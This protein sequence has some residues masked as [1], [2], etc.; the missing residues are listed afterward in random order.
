MPTA[1]DC[2]PAFLRNTDL[3]LSRAA[4]SRSGP[5]KMNQGK[6]TEALRNLGYTEREASFLVLAALHSGYFM[7]RQYQAFADGLRG[8]YENRLVRKALSMGH[9][10]RSVCTNRTELYR[11][12]AR[13]V[14]R[15]IG[16]PESRNRRVRT[17][18]S[19]KARLMSLD[20]VLVHRSHRFLATSAEK[21]EY[22]RD[23]LGLA[24]DLF[25]VKRYRR[26]G[27]DASV[28]RYFVGQDPICLP[29]PVSDSRSL[30][31]FGFIDPGLLSTTSFDSFIDRH[32]RLFV[33]LGGVRL[34]YIAAEYRSLQ[35]GR[36]SFD[37]VADRLTDPD[38]LLP[39]GEEGEYFRLRRLLETKQYRLLD[40]AK[41]DHLRDLSRR[42]QTVE[43]DERFQQWT[44]EK[45]LL[46]R[47]GPVTASF[48]FY[49]L[50]H[51]Y[52]ILSTVGRAKAVS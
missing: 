47:R 29:R 37:R 44:T 19:I 2:R 41:L 42:Y 12:T 48:E 33:A 40:K 22:F 50:R 28:R 31:H 23:E 52:D 36:A 38:S 21:L 26:S 3:V 25:P 24:L 43:T 35:G 10:E 4:P 1:S 17:A 14:Y 27:S 39:R 7:R 9:I 20:F 30:P 8:G 11:I 45:A 32:R 18:Q 49:W 13:E 46:G 51:P 15:A 6:R 16:E 34:V 5:T